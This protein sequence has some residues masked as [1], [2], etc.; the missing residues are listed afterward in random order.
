MS[1]DYNDLVTQISSSRRLAAQAE[2]ASNGEERLRHLQTAVDAFER[3]SGFCPMTPLLWMQYSA[4]TAMLVQILTLIQ[5]EPRLD[6]GARGGADSDDGADALVSAMETR[7]QLLELGLT[8]FPG[9]A[10]LHLHYLE[11]LSSLVEK[12]KDGGVD[13]RYH[14]YA[15]KYHDAIE[16]ALQQVG[17][18]SHRNEGSLV[19]KIYNLLAKERA[20]LTSIGAATSDDLVEVDEAVLD[21]FVRR[22]KT[23]MKDVNAGMG[24]EFVEFWNKHVGN[25]GLPPDSKRPIPNGSLQSIEEGRRYEAKIYSSLVSLED[26]ADV[27]MHS[28]GI[29]ARIQI[30][31][32]RDPIDWGRILSSEEHPPFWSGS[33]GA[34]TANA[35]IHYAQGCFRFRSSRMMGDIDEAEQQEVERQ[36]NALARSVYERGIAEAPTVEA[37]W[38]SYL[39]HLIFL[40]HRQQHS[41]DSTSSNNANTKLNDLLRAAKGVVDRAVRNCPYSVPL[42]Q[43]KLQL[44][45]L[46]ANAGLVILDPEELLNKV[47]VEEAL[48]MKFITSPEATAQLYMTVIQIVR[49]RILFLLA[50]T[51]GPRQ[52][53]NECAGKGASTPSLGYDDSEPI[54]PGAAE[55]VYNAAEEES[56]QELEDLCIDLRE[57]Y[58]EI[59]SNLRKQKGRTS[60]EGRS[61]LWKDRATTETHLLGP[62]M[63]TIGGREALLQ[64]HN[65]KRLE[66]VVQSYE[67]ATKVSQPADPSVFVSYIEAFLGT[68]P[69][70]TSPVDVLAKLQQTRWLHQKALKSVGKAKEANPPRESLKV[71]LDTEANSPSLGLDYETSLRW[72]CQ[73]YLVF[74]HFF[75]S[76]VSY[77]DACKAVEKKLTKTFQ[78]AHWAATLQNVASRRVEVAEEV[79]GTPGGTKRAND[80]TDEEGMRI[81][82]PQ[83]KQKESDSVSTIEQKAEGAEDTDEA[84]ALP[85][86]KHKVKVGN[87][88]YPAHPFTVRVSYLSQKT[89]D[90]DLVDTFR[91]KVGPV[92][93]AKVMREKQAQPHH[94]HDEHKS[95][96]KGWGL[97]QFEDRESVEKA[98]ALSD[99]IGIH[100]KVVKI[101]RS[102]LPAVGLVPPGMHRV[103]PRG[104]GKSTKKN[105]K[106]KE[107]DLNKRT[108]VKLEKDEE[109]RPPDSPGEAIEA[110]SSSSNILAFRPRVVQP[111]SETQR[112][113]KI[114]LFSG[115]IKDLS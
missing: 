17:R 87:L 91:S 68:F 50:Q 10:V 101:E 115:P 19:A 57:L 51:K 76:D 77:S 41:P 2:A 11:L 114:S 25:Q 80:A 55:S 5:R 73:S 21:C 96:S 70:T 37:L 64:D 28:E 6:G 106:R 26:D 102:H 108:N 18:G 13:D 39:R 20:A 49:R 42:F 92:V 58:D 45:L 90:M 56:L 111:R 33:G 16:A 94:Q 100:E 44:A 110:K 46:Q 3:L 104:E 62:L 79:H 1:Y 95:K 99:V 7:I 75:G 67:K 47:V 88:E 38:L 48:G 24:Q 85:S 40:I 9:S 53:R 22:A 93:H 112:K 74:E 107:Q 98:L 71:G 35:F 84:K 105:L 43:Q 86:T 15:K 59:D 61:H 36:I 12:V 34:A 52:I 27:A 78:N 109:S 81:Q 14:S 32:N 89:E 66:E 23:P 8:E 31:L 103:N 72:L 82:P 97:V 4:D 65:S 54:K 30:D 63:A 29:L 69:V 83:K 60:D 113:A